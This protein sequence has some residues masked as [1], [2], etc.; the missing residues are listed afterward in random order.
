[1]TQQPQPEAIGIPTTW[2][3]IENV[4]IQFANQ[5]IGQVDDRAD[6]IVSLG[7][8]NPPVLVG[9]PDQVNEQLSRIAYVPVTPVS[10]VT[11]SRVRV[12][13]LI[14]VLQQTLDIQ[15]RTLEA[16]RQMRGDQ[17]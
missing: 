8:A 15:E 6:I 14:A 3:G 13:E 17:P 7:Q 11:L 2:I 5:F 4:P 12:Q 9:T 1:M 10:R 16:M